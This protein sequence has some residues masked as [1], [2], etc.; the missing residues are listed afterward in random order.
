M[1]CVCLC[2]N[3]SLFLQNKSDPYGPPNAGTN[4]NVSKKPIVNAE[5]VLFLR[6]SKDNKVWLGN[7]NHMG[8]GADAYRGPMQRS[9]N[10]ILAAVSMAECEA[11]MSYSRFGPNLIG[12]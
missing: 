8:W 10:K 5:L 11:H 7:Q 4:Q 3:G 2:V 1:V 6:V 9:R 12:L